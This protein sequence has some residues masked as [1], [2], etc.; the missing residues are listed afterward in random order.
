MKVVVVG[1]GTAGW[2]SALK[3]KKEYPNYDITVIESSAIGVLGAGEGTVSNFSK[4]IFDLDIDPEE[5]LIRSKATIKNGVNFVNWNEEKADYLIGFSS[6]GDFFNKDILD[7]NFDLLHKKGH[8]E[9]VNLYAQLS[10]QNKI[11][12]RKD[13][14]DKFLNDREYRFRIYKRFAWQFD[15]SFVAGYFK[16]IALT[17]GIKVIDA[18]VSNFIANENNDITSVVFEDGSG[19]SCDFIV[20]CS[21]FKRL[22]IGKF[23]NSE[24]TSFR[25]Y[26]PVDSALA[27][28]LPPNQEIPA[29]TQVTAMN[30]GWS[31]QI[32]LH[33]S[34][35]HI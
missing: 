30:Y 28:T 16:E 21:G 3:I 12:I 26:L 25:E 29:H 20:D 22:V 35:I 34:L 7:V 19:E 33:L 24:W 2:I 14:L 11:P 32:P 27:F 1:G 8:M 5:L 18:K 13:E 6:F 10:K 15:A 17:R 23:Y 31:F 4:L 9:D